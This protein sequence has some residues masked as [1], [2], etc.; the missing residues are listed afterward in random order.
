LHQTADPIS[1]ITPTRLVIVLLHIAYSFYLKL[2][3]VWVLRT[4][5]PIGL[6][7]FANGELHPR[8]STAHNIGIL[9]L[10]C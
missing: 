10:T 1:S 9:E 7:R 4:F 2:A 5:G 3:A 6:T 8:L